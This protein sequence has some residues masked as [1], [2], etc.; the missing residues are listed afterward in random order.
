MSLIKSIGSVSPVTL[1]NFQKPECACE[2]CITIN[3]W[4]HESKDF[5]LLLLF[6][7]I[8]FLISAIATFP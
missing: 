6:Y 4:S 3:F 2:Q 5:F 1:D 7:F 8:L